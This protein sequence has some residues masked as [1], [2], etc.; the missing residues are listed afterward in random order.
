ML[1][2]PQR[3]KC[4]STQWTSSTA[5]GSSGTQGYDDGPAAADAASAQCLRS[6]QSVVTRPDGECAA[7]TGW[8][9]SDEPAAYHAPKP[10]PAA[11][12]DEHSRATGAHECAEWPP[13]DG[14]RWRRSDGAA[15]ESAPAHNGT[16]AR[17]RAA[18]GGESHRRANRP[19]DEHPAG[20]H[21]ASRNHAFDG[22][23]LL[24]SAVFAV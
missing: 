15:T 21:P 5:D 16:A 18:N 7:V 19:H 11:P 1:S 13:N 2:N 6:C 4:T 20:W 23:A 8:P 9:V 24:F 10:P 14:A 3:A 12:K 17:H 22:A